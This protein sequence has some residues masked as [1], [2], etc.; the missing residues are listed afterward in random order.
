MGQKG[1]TYL[2]LTTLSKSVTHS[3]VLSITML[4]S[5]LCA[6]L[7]QRRSLL[8]IALCKLKYN[9][10]DWLACLTA[11]L[12]AGVCELMDDVDILH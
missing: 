5:T 2:T 12:R 9:V 3:T 7:V 1:V 8:F 4:F 10:S 6:F 11:A